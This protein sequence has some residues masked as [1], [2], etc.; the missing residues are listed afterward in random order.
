MKKY[1]ST[2]DIS[3]KLK[4]PA[5]KSSLQRIIALS[6]L[7]REN[8]VIEE[9]TYSADVKSALGIIRALGSDVTEEKGSIT[10]KPGN[11]NPEKILN[12]GEAGLGIRMFSP[13]ASLDGFEHE[14]IAEGSLKKRPALIIK[15]ALFSLGVDISLNGDL[16]PVKL[17]GPIKGGKV[18]IDGS[19]SSQ[20]LTGLLISLP[21]AEEDSEI[22]VKSLKSR[23]YIDMTIELVEAF[24]G[25]I[26]N[27]NYEKFIITG[28]QKYKSPGRIKCEGDWS[29]AA[30]FAV[31]AAAASDRVELLNLRRDSKQADKKVID[32]VRQ[33][34]AEVLFKENSV[35]ISRA[36]TL[37]P[38]IF[39]ASDSPDLFPPL[40]VLAAFCRG[41][42]EIKG[43]SRLRHKESD[44]E[45]TITEE[46]AKAGIDISSSGD[47]MK[48]KGGAVRS[49]EADSNNDHRIAMALAAAA[50]KS[51]GTIVINNAEVVAKSYPDFFEDL[52]SIG[53]KV[54][55]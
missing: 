15:D 48:I 23:P 25:R 41:V 34:G 13:I 37:K 24:G 35:V 51:D 52:K 42:S 9:V 27:E 47:V 26:I 6:H 40:A 10:V 43:V 17:K 22:T 16:P 33:T 8:V 50:L 44:R 3:G 46:F 54:D 28:N 55:E 12:P 30:F 19:L 29:G 45:K 53:G 4:I 11:R 14:I 2:S 5:S 49:C 18:C 36:E 31:A 20:L 1:V 39:D 7:C 38:F 21:L 32:V